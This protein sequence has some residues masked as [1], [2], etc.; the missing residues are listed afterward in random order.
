MRPKL[1]ALALTCLAISSSHAFA[2]E[3]WVEPR[4]YV[5]DTPGSLIGDLK[6]GQNFKASNSTYIPDRFDFF[7]VTG[8]DGTTDV[9]GR[10]GDSPALNHPVSSMGLHTVSYQGKFDTITF[11]DADKIVQYFD[12]EGL[13]GTLERHLARGLAPDRFEEKYARCAKALFQVGPVQKDGRMDGLTGMKF[14]LVAEKNPYALAKGETLSVRLYWEGEPMSGKQIRIFRIDDHLENTTIRTDQNGRAEI[15]LKQGGKFLLNAVH[16][17]EGDDDPDSE[18][19]E[20]FSY[21]ASLVFGM[22]DTDSLLGLPK[23]SQ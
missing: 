13:D 1:F 11:R 3:Y 14:E 18:T 17:Y 16:I 9:Q 10:A 7:T 5:L 12:Y 23:E 20:W 6:N 4:Q 21:W 19:P 22:A 15:P 8:P 2:H